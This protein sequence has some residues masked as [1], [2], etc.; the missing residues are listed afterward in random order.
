MSLFFKNYAATLTDVM[1]SVDWSEINELAVAIEQCW[2]RKSQVFICGNGG[3]A[4]NAT[5]IANDLLY[6]IGGPG[7]PG[8]R[9]EALSANSAVITCLAND[10]GYDEIYAQQV[11]VK[12]QPGDLLLVLSGSGNSSNLVKALRA[13]KLLD[14]KT[15]AILGYDGGQCKELADVAIHSPI[16]D[17]QIS[18]DLQM[19]FAHMITQ[20][21]KQKS[22]QSEVVVDPLCKGIK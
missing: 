13:A 6:G 2:Q 4:A 8:A 5:H 21:L 16:N 11:R 20:F 14:V 18:E 15:Y 17:M 1:A 22:S 12:A 3:S 7:R 10:L 9:V 19:I